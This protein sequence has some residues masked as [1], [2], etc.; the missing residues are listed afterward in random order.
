MKI[1]AVIPARY[2]ST[3]LPGKPLFD[4]CGKPMVW[5]VYDKLTQ[6]L[7]EE[8]IYVATDDLR[9]K[10]VCEKHNINVVMTSDTCES[11]LN[12]VWEF[13][14]IIKSD[15]Y[16][17]VNGDEP[18]VSVKDLRNLKE[19]I[20]NNEDIDLI[21]CMVTIKK[22]SDIIDF[23]KMKVVTD[24][25]NYGL[26]LSRSPI[27]YPKDNMDFEYKKF[28]GIQGY[29][30]EVLDFYNAKGPSYNQIIE[31]V[32]PIRFLDYGKKIKFLQCEEDSISVDTL[33][34]LKKVIEI[35]K[36]NQK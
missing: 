6:V 1:V 5:W 14:N 25:E 36:G 22:H 31:D 4:I 19:F 7:D 8:N 34:D 23:S 13:S 12:R 15:R 32:D 16:L 18:L 10:K 21:N 29:S 11:S 20:I 17:V 9:I 27:P 3:R 33:K 26:Y 35:I 2:S 24:C 30:K 28:I